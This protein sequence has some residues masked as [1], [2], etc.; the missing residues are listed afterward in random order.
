MTTTPETPVVGGTVFQN[1]ANRTV[2]T[3]DGSFPI[4]LSA[5]DTL[6]LNAAAD[7]YYL[8]PG[9]LAIDSSVNSVQDRSALVAVRSPLDISAAAVL[10]SSRDAIGQLRVD[11]PGVNTHPGMGG[12]V[13]K[14][15]GALDRADFNGPTAVMVVPG[16]NDPQ[17]R[18]KDARSSYIELTAQVLSSFSIQLQDGLAPT[19]AREGTGADD[20]TVRAD[21]VTLYRDGVKLTQGLDYK[22]SYDTTNNVIRLTPLA[23]IWEQDR[24]YDIVLSNSRGVAISAPAG[25]AVQDGDLFQITDKTGKQVEFE[26]DS[27]YTLQVPQTLA[28]QVPS[29]GGLGITDGESFT[30]TDGTRTV[31]F[32]FDANGATQ[33]DTVPPPT[34]LATIISYATTDSAND[35][36]NKMVTAIRNTSLG[37]LPVN[38]VNSRGRGVHLGSRPLH[39][40]GRAHV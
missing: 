22:F 21:R 6:F 35:I 19:D 28:I 30:I 7:N 13:F 20:S 33:N 10:E 26:F 25:N 18:D 8:A 4:I 14:D 27:G 24:Q 16:D 11:D 2:G 9:A 32:E 23:G 34:Q 5:T 31:Q 3:S 38:V 15:R 1:V 29:N 36:A 40:L 37:L 39:E 12:N 17:G